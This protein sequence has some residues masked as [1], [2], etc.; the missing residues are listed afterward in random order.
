M[1]R[2]DRNDIPTIVQSW[3]YGHARTFEVSLISGKHLILDMDSVRDSACPGYP[4]WGMDADQ[5]A[6]DSYVERFGYH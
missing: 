5:E 6:I 2:V 1:I 4:R 3:N